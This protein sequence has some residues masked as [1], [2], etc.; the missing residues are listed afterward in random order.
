MRH[1]LLFL[2]VAVMLSAC[3][4]M[5]TAT[6]TLA[7]L[8]PV[9]QETTA[10]VTPTKMPSPM[11]YLT[12][13]PPSLILADFPLAIGATWVYSAKISYTDSNDYTKLLTWAGSITDKVI[14]KT[15]TD[16]G[17][18]IFTVQEDLRPIPPQNVW[19]QARM[20]MYT[21]KENGV[22][23]GEMNVDRIKVYQ[24]PIEN[25]SSWQAFTDYPEYET[26]VEHSPEID[27][28]YKN[29]NDCYT[30]TL[31][32]R[33]DTTQDTFCPG[34]GFVRHLYSHHGTTQDE[35]FELTS[36]TPGQ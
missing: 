34:I 17:K 16:D 22:F 33:P 30:F 10:T 13:V 3:T 21:V 32:T 6:A 35:D 23:E 19:R 9:T 5:S 27:T 15:I 4:G 25:S 8:Q 29:F 26:W 24:W 1:F 31:I 28:P 36:F 12:P 2:L 18:I 20:F 11:P 14:D 7:P